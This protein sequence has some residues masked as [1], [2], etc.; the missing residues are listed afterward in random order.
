LT[1]RDKRNKKPIKNI[2]RKKE[3]VNKIV[4]KIIQEDMRHMEEDRRK[5]GQAFQDMIE[6]LEE[7]RQRLINEKMK[8]KEENR[9]YLEFMQMKSSSRFPRELLLS[10]SK[11][12]ISV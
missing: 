3:E 8:E 1:K 12:I 4:D 10:T 2:L 6:T 11:K 9:R 7:K 5:K